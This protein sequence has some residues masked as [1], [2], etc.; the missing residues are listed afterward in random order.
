MTEEVSHG[1][2]GISFSSAA[3][4][5]EDATNPWTGAGNIGVDS[6]LYVRLQPEYK[7]T[8]QF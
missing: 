8:Q 6:T 7:R 1:R 3:L 4:A 2:G 5:S